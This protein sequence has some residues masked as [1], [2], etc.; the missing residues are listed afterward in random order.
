MKITDFGISKHWVGTSLRTH[1]GTAIYRSPEQLGILPREYRAAGNS[2]TNN[3][4]IWALGAIVHEMLTLEIPFRDTYITEDS[5]FTSCISTDE[6]VVDTGLLYGYCHGANPFPC[7]SLRSHGI[8]EDGIDFVKSLMRVNPSE[9]LSAAM[10]LASEW[11]AQNDFTAAPESTTTTL[12]VL[13][14]SPTTSDEEERSELNR[15]LEIDQDSF[16]PPAS[17]GPPASNEPI[18]LLE[19]G[20][21]TDT[22]QRSI[23]PS[24]VISTSDPVDINQQELAI[25]TR[26]ASGHIRS[27]SLPPD[28][29]KLLPTVD[30]IV[31]GP[32]PPARAPYQLRN[33]SIPGNWKLTSPEAVDS[34]QDEGSFTTANS[35][36]AEAGSVTSEVD[37]LATGGLHFSAPLPPQSRAYNHHD[38]R[39]QFPEPTPS[40]TEPGWYHVTNTWGNSHPDRPWQVQHQCDTVKTG[41]NYGLDFLPPTPAQ[42]RAYQPYGFR[43]DDPE[44]SE[45]EELVDECEDLVDE[46]QDLVDECEDLVDNSPEGEFLSPPP[47]TAGIEWDTPMGLDEFPGQPSAGSGYHLLPDRNTPASGPFPESY[48]QQLPRALAPDRPR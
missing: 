8:T 33:D 42:M 25:L 24:S 17:N 45:S 23:R 39:I 19:S 3:I 21:Q 6:D 11:L 10:A 31:I 27:Q 9:R 1:C 15:G 12:P 4:D 48:I 20:Y 47:P 40:T 16:S 44:D 14:P 30:D 5:G 46:S 26:M 41:T 37:D 18:Q 36:R 29:I 32:V 28:D 13:P 43:I 34:Y 38:C 7:A 22:S 2:Y 35:A